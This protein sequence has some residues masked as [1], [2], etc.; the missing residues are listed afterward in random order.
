MK[1]N[2]DKAIILDIQRLST[3]D[4]PGLRTT[5]FFKGCT[6][7]CLWC[8]NPESLSFA[9]QVQWFGTRCIGCG[10]CMQ[11][12]P[13]E[14]V[15]LEKD[16][17]SINRDKCDLCLACINSCP[18]GAMEVK[19]TLWDLDS[20]LYEVLKDRAYFNNNGGGITLSGGDPL[21]QSH[22]AAKFLSRLK[23]EGI[24]TAIDT[25]GFVPVEAF[26][27]V[28]P[29][30]DLI[31]YDLK[32]YD[33]KLHKKFTGAG[34]KLILE[35]AKFLAGYL[36]KHGKPQIWIRTPIIPNATD[37]DE[38][39]S[40]IGSFIADELSFTVTKWELC[41]FNNL[42]RDKYT[43]LDMKWDFKKE[44][45]LTDDRMEHLTEIAR[46]SGVNPDIVS[47][48]GSVKLEV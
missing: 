26:E 30:T 41:A 43:R 46:N 24:H 17:V 3:E 1:E 34:N 47:W 10:I 16:S 35:N 20:L 29:Y 7:A 39:I 27:R 32:L 44:I 11:T 33:E 45:L 13:A 2:N 28:L 25:A 19:G 48:S 38:N 4:G 6:L 37:T 40:A 21:A 5:V 31:L 18:T 9:K 12:C 15:I 8:H 36:R 42:C 23:M 22:F 14:A